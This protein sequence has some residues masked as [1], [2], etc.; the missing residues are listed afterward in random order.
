MRGY[1]LGESLL[2]AAYRNKSPTEARHYLPIL[3]YST[4][5]INCTRLIIRK[6]IVLLSYSKSSPSGLV[7]LLDHITVVSS[8]LQCDIP[9]AESPEIWL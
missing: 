8:M 9:G 1:Q 7:I 6:E 2:N 4:R 5:T 3:A